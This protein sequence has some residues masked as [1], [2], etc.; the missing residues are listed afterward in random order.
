MESFSIFW[1]LS[2]SFGI[3]FSGDIFYGV[4]SF[5]LCRTSFYQEFPKFACLAWDQVPLSSSDFFRVPKS[6][7]GIINNSFSIL[8]S[9]ELEAL[10]FCFLQ[11]SI[12]IWCSSLPR[13]FRKFLRLQMHCMDTKVCKE[14][15]ISLHIFLEVSW[16]SS[17]S[18]SLSCC[19]YSC[20]IGI[21]LLGSK[22]K[23]LPNV[24]EVTGVSYRK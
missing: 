3:I 18:C 23:G 5:C 7:L 12:L 15:R 10:D 6:F 13:V 17:H 24:L 21:V 16:H 19:L 4:S 22:Q 11:Y 20:Y 9:L 2:T 14:S 8:G 1:I